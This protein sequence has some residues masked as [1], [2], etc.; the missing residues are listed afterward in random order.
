MLPRLAN[1][2]RDTSGAV[3]P[4]FAA[5]LIGLVGAGALA[6]DVSRGYA[7]RDELEAAVDAAA[8]AGATQLDGGSDSITRATTAAQGALVQN[9]KRMGDTYESN[10]VGAGDTIRFLDALTNT[11]TDPRANHV[12]TDPTAAKF[13]EITLAPRPMGLILGGLVGA[14]AFNGRAHAVAGYG[15]ALCKVPPLFVCNPDETNTIDLF[16]AY[17]GKSIVLNGKGG[18]AAFAPGN[19]GYLQVGQQLSALQQAMGRSPPLTDCF[20]ETVETRTGDPTSV[21][22]WFNTR[23]DIYASNQVAAQ[24]DSP[25]YAPADITITGL[26]DNSQNPL[27]QCKP[28]SSGTV[29]NGT[30]SAGIVAMAMPRDTCAYPS[31]GSTCTGGANALGNGNWD[32][33]SYFKV[34]HGYTGTISS[35]TAPFTGENW[36]DFYDYPDANPKPTYPTRYQVYLWEKANKDT[37]SIWPTYAAANTKTNQAGDWPKRQCG[38]KDPVAGVPDRRTISAIVLNCSAITNNTPQAT[39]GAVDLFLTEPAATNGNGSIYGEIISSTSDSS[40][41]GQETRVYSVRL[42]E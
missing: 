19:F 42:Y 32:R 13:I 37:V 29:Y 18:S 33:A 35:V 3:A 41:V 24:K 17:A 4:L 12:T 14:G 15:S 7:M 22:D 10:V 27:N 34:T 26:P 30:Y 25:Y 28:K 31:G 23:F 1:F 16:E 11:A 20:G 5:A 39:I 9:A 40:A 6:W 36:A 2:A 21:L 38:T 8:L